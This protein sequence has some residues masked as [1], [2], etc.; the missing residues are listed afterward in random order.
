MKISSFN[1]LNFSNDMKKVNKAINNASL[2]KKEP[3]SQKIIDSLF[4]SHKTYKNINNFNNSVGFVQVANGA[5]N[6]IENKLEQ[7]DKLQNLSKSITGNQNNAF[8]TQIDKLSQNINSLLDTTFNGKSV[9]TITKLSDIELDTKLP[10]FNL[11]NI[12]EFKNKLQNAKQ[13]SLNFMK[14]INDKIE[15]ETISNFKF[16]PKRVDFGLD[17]IVNSHHIDKLKS[18]FINLI[19]DF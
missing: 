5:L 14:Q 19:S 15:N 13:S 3:L 4:S 17:N 12:D 18:K 1:Y 2:N 7:I 6:N 9:F 10:K 8:K 16:Q 11:S